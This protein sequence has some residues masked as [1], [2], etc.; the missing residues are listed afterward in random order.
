MRRLA[1][2]AMLLAAALG[3]ARA[4]AVLHRGNGAEPDT[5]DPQFAG[6]IAEEKRSDTK[7]S[8]CDHSR[9]SKVFWP[10][11]RPCR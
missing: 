1:F 9:T 5:L 11:T 3:A 8:P 7:K 4:E 10:S 6:S 2:A